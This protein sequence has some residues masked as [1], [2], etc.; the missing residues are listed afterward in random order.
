[1]GACADDRPAFGNR[2]T[3]FNPGNDAAVVET[4]DCQLQCSVDGRSVIETCTGAIVQECAAELACGAGTCMTPC[5]AAEADRSSNGCEFY[6]QSPQMARSTPASCYA[7]YIVNTSLQ[8]VDLSVE[9]E[10]K[11]LDVS[12]ALFRTAPG[13]A[14]LIPHTGSIE[15]GESAIVFL[16]EFT[17]Q[18]A[19][20]V[21]W[22]QNYIGCPAGVVPAS[23]VNRIRRGTDMGN[24]FRLKTNVPVSVATIFP[25][26]GAES[27]IP[28]ATLVLPVA[29][30]A[31]EHILVNG[32]E[33]S[34]AGRPSAQIVASEDDTEVTIIPKHDIQDGEG[35]TGGRAGHPATYRLGKGQHLQ[36]V[37]QKELTGSIVTSTKPTTIFGGNSCAFVPALALA[38][39]TLSQQIPAFEQWGAEYVA[40]GY[41]PRLGNEHEPLPYRIV[42]ARDGTMLDYDPAIP[43]GAPTILNAGEMAVFQAGSGD[44]FVVRTQDTE[45]P[46]YMSAHM[47]GGAGDTRTTKAYGNWGDPEFVNVIPARQYMSSYSFY[48]DPTYRETSLVIVRAKTRGEF[49]DVWLECTGNLTGWRTIGTGS[50]YEFVRVDISRNGGPGDSVG[51]SICQYGLQRMRS[52]GPFTATLWGWDKFASYA[53]PGGMAQRKL[54]QKPL[55]PVN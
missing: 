10:G 37:Q 39:D 28:S 35:V 45:H 31:K 26:G 6:F 53:Y 49:K 4:P 24:S 17:P 1:M 47:T 46:I 12:K 18:Q 34:E 2:K 41:R 52:D 32:W 44:A 7:A 15:P 54:V 3:E 42:A 19:L 36:I 5:A 20:P 30:W 27:Y 13:S 25:F 50:E 11:S 40:V 9:L 22:K 55:D 8:P 38:C 33:A 14:D 23:Y 29:S 43:A 48:A 21:D 16:S 51:A